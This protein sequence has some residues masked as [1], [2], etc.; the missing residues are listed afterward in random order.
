M[1]PKAKPTDAQREL[2]RFYNAKLPAVAE[3]ILPHLVGAVGYELTDEEC[4]HLADNALRISKAFIKRAYG[5][6]ITENTDKE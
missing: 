2:R 4:E 5:L 3:Q 6:E 1:L